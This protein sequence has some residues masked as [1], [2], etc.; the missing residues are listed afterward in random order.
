MKIKYLLIFAFILSNLLLNAV[1][2]NI[3]IKLISVK[4]INN[5]SVGND[6]C[7]EAW[8]GDEQIGLY[9]EKILNIE[10]INKIILKAR[11]EEYDKSSD[12]GFLRTV[13]KIKNIDLIDPYY[14]KMNI[15]VSEDKGRYAGNTA[16]WEFLFEIK[17]Y[18]KKQGG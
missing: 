17:K 15:I 7:Y 3:S 6:W 13:I 11:V 12:I 8:V 9:E 4:L 5:N 14:K 10:N 1:E 16:E 18:Q 2:K